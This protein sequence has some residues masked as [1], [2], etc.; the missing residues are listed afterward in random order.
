MR[1]FITLGFDSSVVGKLA[2]RHNM[3]EVTEIYLIRSSAKHPKAEAAVEES[4]RLIRKLN[5]SVRVEVVELDEK[6][7]EGNIARLT[8][9]IYGEGR[10]DGVVIDISGGPRALGLALYVAASVVGVE[11]VQMRLETTGEE[12]AL[13]TLPLPSTSCITDRLA[14]IA[15]YLPTKPSRLARAL[16]I[17]RSTAS[18]E[19]QSLVKKG[20]A[21]KSGNRT[22]LPTPITK[23]L[24]RIKLRR[25]GER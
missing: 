2:G 15:S 18:R 19:L 5:P 16:G 24:V 3:S 9:L 8:D 10:D 11:E 21:V 20:L 23:A 7:F 22:Y 13:R 1:F 25:D 12:V 6:D 17:S 14:V 4:V